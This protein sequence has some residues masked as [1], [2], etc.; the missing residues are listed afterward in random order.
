MYRQE[1]QFARHGV[2]LSRQ[3]LANWVVHGAN[4]WFGKV[5]DHLHE[6]LIKRHYLHADETTLQVLH[7]APLTT[8]LLDRLTPHSH[9][10][11]FEGE[12]YRFRE[13]QKTGP[14]PAL[15]PAANTWS[16]RCRGGQL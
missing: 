8:A 11:L 5:Y 4:Q 10:L 12:S 6:E 16:S 14:Y 13:I 3:T 15:T 1:Q 9:I 7:D 2:P